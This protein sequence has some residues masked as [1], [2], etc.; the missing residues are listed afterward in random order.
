MSTRSMVFVG[1]GRAN[2]PRTQVLSGHDTKENSSLAR[3]PP[4]TRPAVP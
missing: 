4:G 1:D 2:A 3:I